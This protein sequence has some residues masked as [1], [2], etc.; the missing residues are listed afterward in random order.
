MLS[1]VLSS[2][3]YLDNAE[4]RLELSLVKG[5][6]STVTG[7]SM[8]TARTASGPDHRTYDRNIWGAIATPGAH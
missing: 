7:H 2:A 1:G 8:F 6:H 4:L 5:V 3:P